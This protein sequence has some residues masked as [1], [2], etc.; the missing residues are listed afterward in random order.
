MNHE[1]DIDLTLGLIKFYEGFSDIPYLCPTGYWTIG[2][3]C[4]IIANGRQ[5]KGDGDKRLAFSMYP[6]PMDIEQAEKILKAAILLLANRALSLVKVALNKYQSA[7]LVS[8]VYNVGIGNFANSTLLKKLNKGDYDS[9]PEQLKRWVKGNVNGE[10]IVLDG[11]AKRRNK[12]AEY[13]LR[14]E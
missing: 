7:S 6:K 14:S 1:I 12:E 13:W 4:V 5:L 9:V 10:K 3:G 2:Y 11:L 8:F